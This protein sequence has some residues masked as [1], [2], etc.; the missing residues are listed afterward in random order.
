MRI[1]KIRVSRRIAI[2]SCAIC[3]V[4]G[5][6]AMRPLAWA[7]EDVKLPTEPELGKHIVVPRNAD[8]GFCM[9]SP[10]QLDKCVRATVNGIKYS[11]AYRRR[12]VRGN[13]V[14]YLDT[15]DPKFT[16]HRKGCA[17]VMW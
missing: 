7:Q 16:N 3:I 2:G 1:H 4:T 14:T 5:V 10:A 12:G 9:T 17:W 6:L 11:V 8:V 13:V 15:A